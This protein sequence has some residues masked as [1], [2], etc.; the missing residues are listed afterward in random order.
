MT[1]AFPPGAVDGPR[2]RKT[3]AEF[4]TGVTVI[5]TVLDDTPYGCVVNAVMSVSLDPPLMMA[6]LGRTSSTRPMI[7]A[8]G[9]FAI[10]VLPDTAAAREICA[11]FAGKRDDKFAGV[12]Y[13]AGLTGAPLLVDT[14]ARFECVTETAQDLGDHTAFVGRVVAAER[15]DGDPLIFHRGRFLGLAETG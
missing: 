10:N 15:R 7:A 3:A 6:C 12:G 5:T 9:L 14:V 13:G 11:T 4:A 8:A 2:L 1:L